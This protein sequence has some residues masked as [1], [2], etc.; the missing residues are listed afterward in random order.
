MCSDEMIQAAWEHGFYR[1]HSAGVEQGYVLGHQDAVDEQKRKKA[2][3]RLRR[4]LAH[5]ARAM[6]KARPAG[7]A[8]RQPVHTNGSGAAVATQEA[9][10]F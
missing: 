6:T 8:A 9:L 3:V 2:R 1:G 5:R 10:D 4:D 7:V